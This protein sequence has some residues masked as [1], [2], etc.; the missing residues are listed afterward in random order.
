MCPCV[1]KQ[2]LIISG[3]IPK[4]VY[5]NFSI[6]ISEMFQVSFFKDFCWA[7]FKG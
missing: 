2:R 4:Q 7:S 3:V 5:D 1:F 6:E